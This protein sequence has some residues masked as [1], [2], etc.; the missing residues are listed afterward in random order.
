VFS[1]EHR[2]RLATRLLSNRRSS[3]AGIACVLV[4]VMLSPVVAQVIPRAETPGR[5]CRCGC[6]GGADGC[7]CCQRRA[8]P[9][10]T[11]APDGCPDPA[12]PAAGLAIDGHDAVLPCA[13]T[14]TYASLVAKLPAADA[15]ALFGLPARSPDHVPLHLS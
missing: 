3:A 4:L 8:G 12:R 1:T 15:V 6:C 9:G 7:P 11:C 2:G 5:V 13:W 10:V 14:L